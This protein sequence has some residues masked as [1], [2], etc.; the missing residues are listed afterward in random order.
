MSTRRDASDTWSANRTRNPTLRPID[1]PNS[2]A[3]RAAKARAASLRGCVCAMTPDMPRPSSRQY[4]GNCVLLPEPVSPATMSTWFSRSACMMASRRAEMGRSGSC[5]N[6]S[7]A[8]AR[9]AACRAALSPIISFTGNAYLQCL[10]ATFDRLPKT[11]LCGEV[12]LRKFPATLRREGFHG[13]KSTL[14]LCVGGTQGGLRVDIEL[15][16][17]VR[18]REQQIADFFEDLRSCTARLARR[19]TNFGKFFIDFVRTLARVLEIKTDARG[20]LAELVGAHQRRQRIGHVLER[21]RICSAALAGL[22]VLPG[23]TLLGN[24]QGTVIAEN[25][26]MSAGELVANRSGHGLKIKPTRFAGDLRMEH[27]LEQQIAQFAFQLFHVAAFNGIGDLVGLF[28]GIGRDAGEGLL[29]IPRAA[30][31][32]AQTRHDRKQFGDSRAHVFAVRVCSRRLRV[33]NIPAVAPQMLR[34]P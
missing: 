11:L 13:A 8:A 12:Q 25:M 24:A 27:H 21:R 5:L 19:G 17:Q 33:I 26:G 23:G 32:R 7:G 6:T 20:A 15:A 29:P 16:R 31:G 22:D 4:C 30:V 28:D 18:G 2:S 34:S 14:E 1:W 10:L 3:I 9:A